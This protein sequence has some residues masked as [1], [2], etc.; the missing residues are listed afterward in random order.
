MHTN[1]NVK[2]YKEESSI[3]VHLCWHKGRGCVGVGMGKGQSK[4]LQWPFQILVA[5]TV[6]TGLGKL[7]RAGCVNYGELWEDGFILLPLCLINPTFWIGSR[8]VLTISNF[9]R[10]PILHWGPERPG[11]KSVWVEVTVRPWLGLR[12]P[13]VLGFRGC[14][15]RNQCNWNSRVI[16]I[17]FA[18]EWLDWMALLFYVFIYW[19]KY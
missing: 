11:Q 2:V 14:V 8:S 19:D 1:T 3:L 12:F 10:I 18:G 13:W 7:W 4:F 17:I 5:W 9:G 16:V 6:W 15:Q